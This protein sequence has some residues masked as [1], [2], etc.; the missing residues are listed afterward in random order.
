MEAMA[1]A[2]AEEE[3][4]EEK[5]AAE[6]AVERVRA[7]MAEAKAEEMAAAM[8]VAMAGC[9]SHKG[10]QYTNGRS[11]SDLICPQARSVGAC[12]KPSSIDITPSFAQTST[13]DAP[14]RCRR[15]A[16][17]RSQPTRP[18]A[19]RQTDATKPC[20]TLEETKVEAMA[21]A[22]AE[23]EMEEEKAAA[24]KAVERVRAA[25]AEAKAEE[26]AAAMAAAMAGCEDHKG[27]QYTNGR[28]RSDL[29]CRKHAA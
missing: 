7:A 6:K 18:T 19:C 25:M 21:E 27:C 20:Q 15:R 3:M 24:E 29:S 14:Y 9:R 12:V 16:S 26:M 2:T 11:R 5:A 17:S 8:A 22:T 28:S 10:C 4:E 23:E 1:E 13:C